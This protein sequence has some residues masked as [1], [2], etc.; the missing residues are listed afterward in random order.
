LLEL[1]G[2][3]PD[4][5]RRVPLSVGAA[6]N[7]TAIG[8]SGLLSFG[9]G[10]ALFAASPPSSEFSASA[11]FL[12]VPFP[13]SYV[14]MYFDLAVAFGCLTLA[15][16]RRFR[17]DG[18]ERPLYRA[19]ALVILTRVLSLVAASNMA[20]E[21]VISILRYVETFAI[22]L[23]LA[24]LLSVRHNRRLFLRGMI[25]G[26]VIETAGALLIFFS[27]GG[28]ERGVWLGVDNYKLQIF[29]LVACCLAFS[30]KKGR[31]LKIVAGLLLFLGILVTETRTAVVL[32]LLSL[33]P[34]F[35]TRHRAMFRPVLA[36]LALAAVATVPVLR[37][38]P[39]AEQNVMKRVDEI[40]TGGG[41]IGLRFILW[42]MAVAAYV[43]HPITGIGSGGFARQQNTLYL[44]IND[45]YASGYETK[46]DSQSTHNTVLGVAAETGTLGLIAYFF[47]MAAVV[48]ICLRGI[49]LEA[50]YQDPW[51]L[52]AC[53]CLLAMMIGDWWGQYSF[54]SPSTCLLGF[55]LGWCR[56][57][58][59][60]KRLAL[61]A[62]PQ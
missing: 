4:S 31:S 36:V 20:M 41:T 12:Q 22:V 39:E 43:S 48:G 37:L 13:G 10:L 55:I 7:V 61:R 46:Y 5:S 57:H 15:W 42:E 1:A 26:A 62:D 47:W 34:L 60:P 56:A 49:R 14:I 44:Q 16:N 25:L 29:L 2:G 17:F 40:W 18:Q 8:R 11:N 24:N 19:L 33:L 3:L 52:A 59:E 50:L 30:E 53:A 27:S 23:L 9:L 28:E 6:S 35:L 38:L 58:Q 51:V 21:Q 32:F 54:M 45:V